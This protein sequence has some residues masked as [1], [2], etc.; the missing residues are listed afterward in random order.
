MLIKQT[1]NKMMTKNFEYFNKLSNKKNQ[2]LLLNGDYVEESEYQFDPKNPPFQGCTIM[3]P[4]L[5]II[6]KDKK[7]EIFGSSSITT[8]IENADIYISLEKYCTTFEWEQPWLNEKKQHISYFINDGDVPEDSDNFKKAILFTIDELKKNKKIHI[9]CISGHGRTGMFLSA[10][11][12]ETMKD[13][14]IK[15]NISAIDYVRDNYCA[16]A[17]E[18]LK[19]V[20]FLETTFNIKW[21]EE[22]TSK[23]A[24]FHVEFEEENSMTFQDAVKKVGFLNA[25]VYNREN[26]QSY[27]YGKKR[28]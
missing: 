15:K 5:P 19:Q 20:L 17:V 27:T 13:Y 3:H 23:L 14:L 28:L 1:W 4:P 12:Q 22:E 8:N 2:L 26:F 21:P 25:W 11:V 18:N 7:F 6:I 24:N 10:I 16:H 9:G